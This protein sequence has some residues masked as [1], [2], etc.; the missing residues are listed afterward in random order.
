MSAATG[1]AQLM[2]SQMVATAA[3]TRVTIAMPAK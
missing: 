3:M 2:E 1:A